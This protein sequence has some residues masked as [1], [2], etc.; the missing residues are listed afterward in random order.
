MLGNIYKPLMLLLLLTGQGGQR[1]ME[2]KGQKK[3]EMFCVLTVGEARWPVTVQDFPACVILPVTNMWE[4]TVHINLNL[5]Y[6]PKA[7]GK[8]VEILRLIHFDQSLVSSLSLLQTGRR[9]RSSPGR[10][11]ALTPENKHRLSRCLL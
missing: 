5:S 9:T 11:E 4:N 8:S 3:E 2:E 7:E 1:E 6:W 10:S